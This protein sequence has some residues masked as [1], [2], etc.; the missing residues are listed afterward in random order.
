MRSQT[1]Q[2]QGESGPTVLAAVILSLAFSLSLSLDRDAQCNVARI[3]LS[4]AQNCPPHGSGMGGSG[5]TVTR[6]MLTKV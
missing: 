4:H 1:L 2:V 3:R 6:K 5:S